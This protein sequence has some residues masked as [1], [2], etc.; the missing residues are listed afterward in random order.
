MSDPLPI[1]IH[2]ASGRMGRELVALIQSDARLRLHAAVVRPD[3]AWCGQLVAGSG[4]RYRSDF[5]IDAAA[6]VDF[7]LPAA[8]PDL[9]DALAR[10][11]IPLVSGTTG[12]DA[13]AEA[14]LDRLAQQVPVLWAPNFSLG[15]MV[16]TRLARDAARWL[17]DYDVGIVDT[18][19][20]AKRDAPSGTALRLGEAIAEV[21]GR[22]PEF[23]CLRV[24]DVV[25]DHAVVIAG[26]DELLELRHHAQ[27]RRLFAR[28]ALTA[29]DWLL[30]NGRKPGRYRLEDVLTP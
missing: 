6:V 20:R 19:H 7:S 14:A 24:G 11:G 16:L 1:C 9:C 13:A 2:G 28:G 22:P 3:S 30:R 21:R 15:V 27:D 5:P 29:V 8:L 26:P 10:R 18:H 12:L 4:L 23:A 17:A 25:G